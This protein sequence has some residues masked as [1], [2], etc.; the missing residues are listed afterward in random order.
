MATGRIELGV[1]D[2]KLRQRGIELERRR[3]EA[4]RTKLVITSIISNPLWQLCVATDLDGHHIC[5]FRS[6]Q[7]Q[8]PTITCV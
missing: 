5:H 7:P 3:I 2:R 8:L 4:G 1:E 6:L